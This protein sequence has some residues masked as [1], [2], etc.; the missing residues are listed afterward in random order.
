MHGFLKGLDIQ[1]EIHLSVS[2]RSAV[3]HR[4]ESW[5]FKGKNEIGTL[6]FANTTAGLNVKSN[7]DANTENTIHFLQPAAD[8]TLKVEGIRSLVVRDGTKGVKWNAEVNNFTTFEVMGKDL[9]TEKVKVTLARSSILALP[10][11]E[12]PNLELNATGAKISMR[13]GE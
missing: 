9:L 10:S 11:G 7:G 6:T 3:L 5:V 13:Q 8:A 1:A 2:T 12:F 4:V